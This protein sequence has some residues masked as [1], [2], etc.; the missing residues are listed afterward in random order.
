MS[1]GDETGPP[2]IRRLKERLVYETK[3]L[4]LY[5][6]DVEKPEGRGRYAR[7]FEGEPGAGP[8]VKVVAQDG[9]R[10]ILFVRVYRY[11]L[12]QW[13]WE[14]PGGYGEPG[15]SA[16]DSAARELR[17]ETGLEGRDFTQI[18][19]VAPSGGLLETR[20]S[21][22]TARV[23]SGALEPQHEEGVREVRW[24]TREEVDA[25]VREGR[26]LDATTL[27]AMAILDRRR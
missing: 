3:W 9:G 20:I 24:L 6:D 26:I 19:S 1:D 5:D 27:A 11:P 18:G 23:E 13:S 10:R 7:A 22:V 25:W 12:E 14:M 16:I 15:A 8:H 4:R 21:I 2:P 17:E